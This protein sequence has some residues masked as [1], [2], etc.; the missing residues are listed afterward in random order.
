M[1]DAYYL[2]F[3]LMK[4]IAAEAISITTIKDPLV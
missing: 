1:I 3:S 4:E 2:E